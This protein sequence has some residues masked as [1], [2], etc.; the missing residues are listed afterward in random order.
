MPRLDI[1]WKYGKRPLAI[2]ETVPCSGGSAFDI[3]HI[4][5]RV[6]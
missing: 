2:P 6:K 3:D 4:A 1:G 5:I